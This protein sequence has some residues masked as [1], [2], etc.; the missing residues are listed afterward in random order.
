[1]THAQNVCGNAHFLVLRSPPLAQYEPDCRAT[2]Q[3]SSPIYATCIA[4]IKTW[5]HLVR[6]RHTSQFRQ[7]GCFG[8]NTLNRR[9]SP[10]RLVLRIYYTKNENKPHLY[11]SIKYSICTPYNNAAAT[12]NSCQSALN[13]FRSSTDDGSAQREARSFECCGPSPWWGT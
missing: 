13:C 4:L 10:P 11:V 1:M 7:N 8:P 5:G 12:W 3:S 2:S 6:F 9:W